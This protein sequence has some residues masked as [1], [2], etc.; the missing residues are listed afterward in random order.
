M[1]IEKID[2]SEVRRLVEISYKDDFIGFEKYHTEPF[3]FEQ[4]VDK[5]VEMLEKEDL[6]YFSVSTD[7][8]IGYLA[9][10]GQILFSFAIE[11]KSRTKNIL[12]PWWEG[13]RILMEATFVVPLY[14]NNKRAINFLLKR[15][16]KILEQKDNLIIL[17]NK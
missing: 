7:R 3:T 9:T 13:I 2:K 12:L 16:M 14:G 6:E 8:E 17:I 1:T 4:A 15:G 5:T 10:H 11:K